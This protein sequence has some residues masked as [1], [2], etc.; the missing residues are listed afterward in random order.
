MAILRRMAKWRSGE[1]RK[2]VTLITRH[3][4]SYEGG[5]YTPGIL[6]KEF[7]FY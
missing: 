3:L 2:E 6:C 5:G 7:V 1:A 4:Q